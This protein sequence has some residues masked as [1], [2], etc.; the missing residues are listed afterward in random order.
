MSPEHVET[1]LPD[2]RDDLWSLA[3]TLY[4]SLYGFNPFLGADVADTVARIRDPE[5]TLRRAD[6][7]SSPFFPVALCGDRAGRPQSAAQ[8]G[9]MAEMLLQPESPDRQPLVSR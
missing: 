4:E 1:G 6:V 9:S 3:V 2:H 7:S 5:E 8:L